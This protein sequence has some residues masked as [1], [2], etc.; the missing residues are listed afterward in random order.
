MQ[1]VIKVNQVNLPKDVSQ[2][3][4]EDVKANTDHL[5]GLLM[6]PLFEFTKTEPKRKVQLDVYQQKYKLSKHKENALESLSDANINFVITGQKP[7]FQQQTNKQMTA[8]Y[9]VHD[10]DNKTN[11]SVGDDSQNLSDEDEDQIFRVVLEESGVFDDTRFHGQIPHYE[12]FHMRQYF[13]S[14]KGYE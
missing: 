1:K 8:S 10:E 7:T 9:S 6:R 14:F 2:L 12:K 13:S 4:P 5:S 11:P 3:S